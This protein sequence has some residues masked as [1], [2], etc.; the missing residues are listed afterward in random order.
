MDLGP[1]GVHMDEAAALPALLSQSCDSLGVPV[2][3]LLIMLT[4]FVLQ[5][6]DLIRTISK[7]NR[8]LLIM[9]IRP[10]GKNIFHLKAFYNSEH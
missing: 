4:C 9:T 5:I 3:V 6:V 7:S 1:K 2:S 8:R 10:N